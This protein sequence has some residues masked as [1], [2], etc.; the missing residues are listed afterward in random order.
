MKILL[1]E[2]FAIFTQFFSKVLLTIIEKND[3]F[4]VYQLDINFDL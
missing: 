4:K 1:A 3:L 2:F